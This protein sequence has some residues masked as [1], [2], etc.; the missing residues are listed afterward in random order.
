MSEASPDGEAGPA[1]GSEN[2]T[3]RIAYAVR[4]VVDATGDCDIAWFA[5]APTDTFRQGI[6]LAAWY[7][8]TD[9]KGYQLQQLGVSDIPDEENRWGE[10][11]A[12]MTDDFST[13][14]VAMLPNQL[15]QN[16]VVLH[17]NELAYNP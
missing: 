11:A 9:E 1:Y 13:L 10:A 15:K 14:D 2:N 17:E 16:G 7:Y 5:S 3:G 12:A 8:F 4:T 6:V